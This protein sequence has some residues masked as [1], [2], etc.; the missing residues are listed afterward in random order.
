MDKKRKDH[1]KIF[2]NV[3]AEIDFILESIIHELIHL[4]IYKKTSKMEYPEIENLVDSIFI[5]SG[6]DKLFRKYK[7][8]SIN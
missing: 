6:L 1:Y 8:Q 2:I 3:N 7:K 4:F 5:N